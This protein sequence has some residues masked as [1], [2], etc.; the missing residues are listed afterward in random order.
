MAK[1]LTLLLLVLLMATSATAADHKS[2]DTLVIAIS[3]DFAPFTFLNAEGNPAGMFVDIWRLW[4]QKT[5]QQI[6][7]ISSDWKTSI[8]N[9]KDG[10][11]DIH[12]GLLYSHERFEWLG[13]SLPFYEVGVSLFYPLKQRKIAGLD[14]LPGQTI[15]VVRGSQVAQFLG[16]HYPGIR[17]L[18]CDTREELVR[19]SRDGKAEGFMAV[20]P[21]GTFMIDRLGLSGEFATYDKILYRENFHPGI[22][23]ENK[24][25][26]A[27][28]DQGFRAISANAL[29]E[30]EARWIPDPVKRYYKV[31]AITQLTAKEESWLKDHKTVRVGMS[32]IFPPLKFVDNGVIKGIEP[33][34][35]NL[36]SAYTGI[37][38]DYV[39]CDFQVMDAKVKSGEIDMFLSF[40]IPERLSY[41]TFTEPMMES[42]QVVI[43]RK[44]SPFVSGL[45]SFKGKKI[46]IVK[47]V[48][49]H[50]KLLGPYPDIEAV[51]VDTME[52]MFRAVS[53]SK[54]DALISRT[55]YAGYAMRNYPDL[56]IAGILDLPPEPYLYAV[57]NDYPELVGILD[58]AIASIPRETK[59]SIVQKWFTVRFEYHP[60][61][62]EILKWAS[63][64]G[65]AF[66]LILGLS[67]FWNTRLAGEI[68]NRR[69]AEKRL[70][71]REVLL[72]QT[73]KM[74]KVGGWEL[75]IEKRVLT[76][77]DEVYRIH[78]AGADY[79]PTVET[80]IEF[81]APEAR[82][83][84]TEV[85]QKAMDHGEPFD[86]ELPLVTA[87]GN[88]RWVHLIGEA[89]RKEGKTVKV[90]GTFQDITEHK[91][92]EKRSH[93]EMEWG[94]LLLR[95][96][97]QAPQLTDRELYDFI[98]EQITQL[99]DSAIGFFHLVSDDQKEIILTTWNSEALKNC[100]AS[101]ATH[102]PIEQAGNWVDCVRFRRPIIYNDFANSPNRKGLPEG[103][104]SVR[105]FMSIPVLEGEKVRIIFGVGNKPEDYDENDAMQIQVVA[106]DLQ[107]IIEQRRADRELR[108]SGAF[109]NTLLHAIP[110][111]VFYKDTEGR[112]LGFNK[113]FEE[114]FG[115]TR[116]ELV[117]K[118]V[119][120]VAPVELA[121]VYHAKDLELLRHSGTQVYE[122]HVKDARGVIHDVIFHKA[123]FTDPD[124]HVLGLIGAILDIT[125]RK[126]MEEALRESEE[127]LR[128]VLEGSRLGFWDWNIETGE[129]RR[130]ERWAGML[131]YTLP[132]IEFS[133]RQWTDLLH[134]D[135]RAAARRSIEDH[136]DGSAPVHEIEYRM[137]AKDGQYKWIL[138]CARVVKRDALG[139]PVR[140]CGTHTDIT[141]RKLAEEERLQ[142]EQRLQLVQK[143]ESL[144]RMAGGIAHN[145]NNILGV[146]IGNLDLALHFSTPESE[147]LP[148]IAEA[149]KAS[150]RAVEI[151]QLM[152][153]YL[154]QVRGAKES[155]DL[156][157][158]GR[159][160]LASLDASLPR[161]VRIET[162]FSPRELVVRANGAHI[163]QILAS[164]ILN[165]GE[166]IGEREG[167]IALE[168]RAMSATDLGAFR[169]F[170]PDWKP[171]AKEYAC[172]SVT[173]DG[174]G[175]DA[176][177]V[178]KIF[179]PFFSTKFT[180]RGLGLAV[181]LGLV[182]AYGGAIAVE[183]PPGRGASFRVF[184]PL[185]EERLPP[186]IVE[187]AF[188][189]TPV[190]NQGLALLAEGEPMFRNVVRA[191]LKGLG[192]EVVAASD[193]IEAVEL[194]RARKAAVRLVLIDLNMPRMN[195]WETLAAVRSI[196]P[197]IPVVLTGGHDKAGVMDGERPG[198]PQAFLSKPYQMA[199][200]KAVLETVLSPAAVGLPGGVAGC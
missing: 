138:D 170:P 10:K 197:D 39:I 68:D 154:G 36:L 54:A 18:A 59:D 161:S 56:K 8:A 147:Y 9:L 200:L 143:A 35:L 11:A 124:G 97:E 34:Y 13:G 65:G 174:C 171:K 88:R 111:P 37:Q 141:A 127:R 66:V 125:E 142:L 55:Y 7:F 22:L 71:E 116:Q 163:R 32:P 130:N 95:L 70:I 84:V 198:R 177:V 115:Q 106:N 15:A 175:I 145:F 114:F 72:N 118:S 160:A 63:V 102:Y 152:L 75:D 86:V 187:E 128:F 113:S 50:N 150:L 168:I 93:K 180:G 46:A 164:L 178:E 162:G 27:L 146:V 87:M 196:R 191:M 89:Y 53:E 123:S 90:G 58:K 192:F 49:L 153:S 173:D 103:H 67:L 4:A 117:G 121:T 94:I 81:Y 82:P 73:G 57:R 144:G 74:A 140:M 101:Y 159:E 182:R 83:I 19:A 157:E 33:D 155:L 42:K 48:K 165:A 151:S 190:E 104:S 167:L 186:P 108:K 2:G 193:G 61:W 40:Y 43:T 77:T 30:I 179:D 51:E 3:T 38:F 136:L 189:P 45:G 62:S 158:A 181:T 134:P 176:A 120:D 169:F 195:G 26:L 133:A 12:S 60:N 20:S 184:L 41:M 185:P 69:Q 110:A 64:I 24:E 135:D 105:R 96:Y 76:W 137:R 47:G 132:E 149:K 14:E 6:E 148:N 29:A 98:L 25:L 79:R 129:V 109:W 31:S 156:N 188:I 139:K 85:V 119:F 80:A 126:K 112:Y 17:I 28:V 166:A 78:E 183:S 122:Q 1:R 44:D 199:Q 99:T 52:D 100:A 5:G 16:E 107:K 23:K 91:Q 172:L 131:G 21:V 92:A 194:F